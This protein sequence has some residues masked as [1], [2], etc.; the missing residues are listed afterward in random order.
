MTDAA[1]HRH[2]AAGRQRRPQRRPRAPR[3]STV[4]RLPRGPTSVGFGRHAE[5]A[6]RLA[7]KRRR[8]RAARRV[9]APRGLPS[10]P[11]ATA[12]RRTSSRDGRRGRAPPRQG[13][14]PT[15][16]ALG[17]PTFG[18][19]AHGRTP[20]TATPGSVRTRCRHARAS[21]ASL[22]ATDT[23]PRAA[24]RRATAPNAY[25]S[26]TPS[27]PPPRRAWSTLRVVLRVAPRH[28]RPTVAAGGCA[29]RRSGGARRAAAGAHA[30]SD[31]TASRPR[32][33]G[34]G[35]RTRTSTIRPRLPRKKCK[36]PLSLPVR[37][38]TADDHTSALL[39]SF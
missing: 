36:W 27:Q 23:L 25:P 2:G 39:T 11:V 24:R 30:G 1:A 31:P 3:P 13:A 21:R 8:R 22:R 37:I 35:V 17:P 26:P 7:H 28:G 38:T 6:R 5:G 32:L 4:S 10:L 18:P 19:V 14:R 12:P 16:D 33:I 29:A 9:P 34:G 20:H 15:L